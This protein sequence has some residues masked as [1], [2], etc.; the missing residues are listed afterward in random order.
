VQLNVSEADL[1]R[2][3]AAQ[4]PRPSRGLTG[5]LAKHAKLVSPAVYGA[6]TDGFDPD[7]P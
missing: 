4:A 7:A 5:V 3:R 2:R 1:A 6:V